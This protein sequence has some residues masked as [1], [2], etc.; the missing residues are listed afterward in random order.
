MA[1]RVPEIYG[2]I[3]NSFFAL[4]FSKALAA[5]LGFFKAAF[6]TFLEILLFLLALGV[7]FELEL[8]R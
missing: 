2:S 7:F 5:V 8:A 4:V 1:V 6:T 3:T